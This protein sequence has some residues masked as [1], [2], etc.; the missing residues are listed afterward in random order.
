MSMLLKDYLKSRIARGFA[1]ASLGPNEARILYDVL[2]AFGAS[3]GT[4]V[5]LTLF[6]ETP[7][8]WWLCL[9]PFGL[10]GMNALFG[11]YSRLKMS[12]GRVKA[13]VLSVSVVCICAMATG[14]TRDFAGA[15]LWG[16]LAGPALI[17]ARLFLA[18][19]QSKHKNLA[20]RSIKQ[21]GPILITGGAGYIGT[22]L[23]KLLL[24][25][26][27]SI[28]VLDR[29]MYGREPLG[30]FLGKRGFELIEGDVTDVSKLT[31][32]MHGASAVVH[33]AGLVGDPACAVDRDFTRQ[34]NI[35]STRL[36]KEVA[37]SMGIYRFVFA[38]SCS[39]Y[40]VSDKQAKEGDTPNPVSLY[41]ET[42]IDSE[43]ELLLS[44][45]D[46]FFVTILRFATV[47]GHSRRARF[48]LVG[49]LFTAQ[50]MNEGLITVIGPHQWR[51]FVHVRDLANAVLMVLKA[52]PIV[53][54]NQI[55]NVGDKRLNFT[56]LQL[57]EAVKSVVEKGRKRVEIS[58][59][60]QS[61]YDRRNYA[62]SFEKIQRTLGFEAGTLLEEGIQEMV[63][64]LK[65]GTYNHYQELI[66]S[67]VAMTRKTLD[68]FYDPMQM[69]RLYA[70]LKS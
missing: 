7:A 39:V 37:Q 22:C 53:V 14:V 25:N 5:Y 45:R 30:D 70:P 61:D 20:V 46:D 15:A 42:K 26:G 8:G 2:I 64:H 24:D 3:A 47:F 33:L 6:L 63:D 48:D 11:I 4:A 9:A 38:S 66:Y 65:R 27:H 57:A 16:M 18:L 1:I 36:V 52:D 69:M 28:R 55:F 32:S 58:V 59:Q 19:P 62:V 29:L 23:V 31:G 40:G 54:Q 60:E 68:D 41:A 44:S 35:I 56:I 34:M 17:L 10:V 67:N 13:A 49:N 51:P 21:W 43:K 50:A 12:A